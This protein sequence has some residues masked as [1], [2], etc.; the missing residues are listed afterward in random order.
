[1]CNLHS[2]KVKFLTNKGTVNKTNKV[3]AITNYWIFKNISVSGSEVRLNSGWNLNWSLMSYNYCLKSGIFVWMGFIE[4]VENSNHK[5]KCFV[6][7][8]EFGL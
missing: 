1:M 8:I 5:H 7:E 2:W 6:Y 4:L 3:A